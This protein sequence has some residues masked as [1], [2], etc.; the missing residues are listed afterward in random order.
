MA[1]KPQPGRQRATPSAAAAVSRVGD[2]A[3]A[4]RH[5]QAIAEADAALQPA[6]PGAKEPGADDAL[7]LLDLRAESHIALGNLHGAA[8]D[9]AAMVQRARREHSA[10][11][12][13]MALCR[14]SVVLIRLGRAR[15]AVDSAHAALQEAQRSG[16]PLRQAHALWRLSYAQSSCRIEPEASQAQ[17]AQAA[18]IFALL[19]DTV[20]QGRASHALS[21]A[22]WVFNQPDASR[23]AAAEAL[24]L[25]RR[26]GDLLNQAN[27]QN[28]LSLVE[29]DLAAALRQHQQSLAAFKAAGYVLGQANATGNLG[30]TYGELGLYRRARRLSLQAADI[31]R[32]AGA[33]NLLLVWAWN[34]AQW[35][36][37]A[38]ALHELRAFAAEATALTNQMGDRRFLGSPEMA[39][40]WLALREGRPAQAAE[41]FERVARDALA[42]E[43][44]TQLLALTEAGRA[45]LAAGQAGAALA[46]TQRAADIHRSLQLSPSSEVNVAAVWWRHSQALRANGKA[47]AARDALQRAWRFL[48][49]RAANLSDEGLRRSYLHQR[50][51]HRELVLAWLQH[52]RSQG[53]PREQ[54]EAH[55]AGSANL[56]EPFQRLVDTGLRLNEIQT[57]TELVDFLVDEVTELCGAERVLLVLDDQGNVAPVPDAPPGFRIVGAHL[58]RGED[59]TALLQAITP[60]LQEAG[61]HRAVSLRH[62]PQG[63]QAMD[64]RSCL[65]APLMAQN[66]PLG[67]LY[68]DLAGAF[69]RFADADRDLLSLLAAQA[70][71]ALANLRSAAGLERKVLDRTAELQQRVGE[72]AVIN[73]I[74][75]GLAG[76][77]ELDDAVDLIGNTL[78]QVFHDDDIAI[79]LFTTEPITG[80][81][82]PFVLHGRFVLRGGER[83]RER[84][85]VT[86]QGSAFLRAAHTRLP[87]RMHTLAEQLAAGAGVRGLGFSRSALLVPI[88]GERDIYGAIA[89][90]SHIRDNAYDEAALRLVSTVARTAGMALENIDLFKATRVSLEHQTATAEILKVTSESPTDVRPTFKAIVDNAQH[91]FAAC[92]VTVVLRKGDL[93]EQVAGAMPDGALPVPHAGTWPLDGED[94]AGACVLGVRTI[95]IAD[96]EAATTTYPRMGG[97]VLQ[98]GCKSGLWV[99]LVRDGQALGCLMILRAATGLFFQKGIQLA[100]TFADQAVIA[101][102]NVR[103]F[104]ETKEA[105]EQQ[106]ASAEVLQV[107]SSSVA[108]TQP[109]FDKILQS[110]QRLFDSQR[111]SITLVDDDDM[112]QLTADLGGNARTTAFTKG[113]YPLPLHASLQ[114]KAI[115]ERRILHFPDVLGGQNVPEGLRRIGQVVGNFTSLYA[116]LWWQDRGIGAIVVNRMP[117][118]AFTEREIALLKTFSD[119]AVIAIQNARL[120][121]QTQEARAAAEAANVA[122][123]SFLATMS[124]E[125]RTPMNGIIGMSGLLLDTPLD[126]DQR[127]LARTVR[128]SGESLL[129]IINDILDFSKIEA[130]RLDV[131]SAA[132]VLRE[133]IGSALDLVRHRAGEKKLK[134][135]V[136]IADDVPLTVKGDSTRLRQILLNLLSNALKF[137][138]AGE[139]RLTLAR[140]AGDELHFAIRDSGIGLTP[141]GM[142]KLFQSFSQADSSTTRK[143]GGTGLGLVISKRLAE[144]MGGTMTAESEGA[145]QGST[146]RFHIRAEAV[147]ATAASGARPA[148]KASIDPQMASRHPLRILLAEDNLVNQKLALRLLSQMGYAAD[149]VVNGQQAVQR[150]GQQP[151]D[152]VLMDV[153]M[154]QM[155]GLEASRRITSQWQAH[156]RPRIIAMTANAMQGDREDCLAAG[157]D[158]YVTKP[159]RVEALVL[160]LVATQVRHAN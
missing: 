95:A 132:F 146:F 148:A 24:A 131:E 67:Y 15:A 88:V 6:L 153:Q 46:A 154:P 136:A 55:L 157:M 58:P 73:T 127:D 3:W 34:L 36:Y 143:Y 123:S 156:E 22:L 21:H 10:A 57:E 159:I 118:A 41:H 134:L 74:Q 31:T 47:A 82:S 92:L 120:F 94:A 133:C 40:G 45:H 97:W 26:S 12:T 13:A 61:R 98:S 130:G 43:E 96:C 108:D 81:K 18:A 150:V 89:L 39:R 19:G 25:A 32:R 107:I 112:V 28:A 23:V 101:I 63:E 4:G 149:V 1:R 64:Q 51:E 38:G 85:R 52:A 139:V 155:D 69:G 93:L 7:A 129:T 138:E 50:R 102:E 115:R 80:S 141:Q 53:L 113:F 56:R 5:E 8:A 87:V 151:Y 17:A 128:E 103:L 29:D 91:L 59:E 152:V 142:A 110:C 65:V 49:E 105:L 135:V 60:W 90:E 70:A 137:T 125:I 144:I 79:D 71:V 2:L 122:K 14:E 121:R 78:H 111:V 75:Q 145:G 20:H 116:P 140:G 119:Q 114:G 109:V 84:P 117:P 124:H 126:D 16:Q 35:A 100:Q 106:T 48:L 30:N 44:E 104:N 76:R 68:C 42:D 33:L 27:A 66:E 54:R 9:A 62:G 99:P 83:I 147:A 77:P 72:L 160:A 158:D 86:S 11:L 37:E